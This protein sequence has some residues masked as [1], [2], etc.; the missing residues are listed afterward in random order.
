MIV[1]LWEFFNFLDQH[2][3]NFS[4]L[5]TRVVLTPSFR[6]CKRPPPIVTYVG[7][8]G[9]THPIMCSLRVTPVVCRVSF[10]LGVDS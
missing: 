5:G 10:R 3:W 8:L 1:G 6:E 4:N 9:P 2:F 7:F